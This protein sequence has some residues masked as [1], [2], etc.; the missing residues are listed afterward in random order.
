MADRRPRS[1]SLTRVGSSLIATKSS[2]GYGGGAPPTASTMA[3][4]SINESLMSGPGQ[5]R[6]LFKN[7]VFDESRLRCVNGMSNKT[8]TPC[9]HGIKCPHLK[10]GLCFN[11]HFE[12]EFDKAS[13]PAQM[14]DVFVEANIVTMKAGTRL[15]H[16]N[17]ERLKLLDALEG[18]TEITPEE[19]KKMRE[20][21]RFTQ[22]EV[23]KQAKYEAKMAAK[24]TGAADE[25]ATKPKAKGEASRSSST[26]APRKGWDAPP[27][28]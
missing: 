24:K 5:T 15:H 14:R 25:T 21:L 6:E 3:L 19:R 13:D 20:A 17:M 12:Q 26:P 28:S 23:D 11:Y 18:I 16:A 2:G 4:P 7:A 10:R 1:A 8:R 27:K 9:I 22:N